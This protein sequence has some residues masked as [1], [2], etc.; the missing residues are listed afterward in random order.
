[1]NSI[2]V[3]KDELR[4]LLVQFT[5]SREDMASNL[6]GEL[7]RNQEEVKEV[8]I[9]HGYKIDTLIDSVKSIEQQT[10][11]TNGR[12]T[13]LEKWKYTIVGGM[14]VLGAINFPNLS[15]IAKIFAGQ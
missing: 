14:V 13:A 6:L 10:I 11:K 1:M 2:V 3:N 12:V 5:R 9:N 4:E 15:V 7:K 8:S